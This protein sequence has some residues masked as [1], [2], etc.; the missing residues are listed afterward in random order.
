MSIA[1][2]SKKK[3]LFVIPSL[4]G[5][6]AERVVI[7]LINYLDKDKH[8]IVLVIFKDIRDCEK[9]LHSPVEIICLNKKSRWDFFKLILRLR[10][11]MLD[12]KPNAVIS[13]MFYTNIISVIARLFLRTKF[14]LII[15]EHNYPRKY[16]PKAPLGWLKKWL[17][18]LTYPRADLIL[19]VSKSIERV[20]KEDFNIQPEKIKT[21]Y[22]PIPLE[23]I[24]GKSQE[25]VEHPFFKN[26]NAKVIIGI[27]RLLEQK[28]FD[29]L[30][31]AFSIVRGKKEKVYLII[32][33]EGKLRE[34]L[35]V[36]SS[37]LKVSK[38]I[39]FVGFKDNP[40]AWISKA[41]IFVLSSDYEGLPMVLLEA[42][43][44][45][46][47]VVSTDCPSGP[48][49]IITN[50][51]NGILVPTANEEALA[52]AIFN[53]LN[54]K[55]LQKKFSEEGKKRVEDFRVEKIVKQYEQVF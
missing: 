54:D 2:N 25:G 19:T 38:W 8:D 48:G 12:Y 23:D 1:T 3:L 45:G 15:S 6:G 44:C 34:E 37:Q 20:I 18:N 46:V 51:K 49:E 14:R 9:N 5:G 11:I 50:G 4:T 29:S 31:R 33:G 36:L 39:D 53:L 47:P 32:L 41:D 24:K 22:N 42:M 10:K 16:L 21:I 26:G 40:Y 55:N 43:A 35:E 13:L 52:D 27:G 30:L 28:R 7:H 17:M